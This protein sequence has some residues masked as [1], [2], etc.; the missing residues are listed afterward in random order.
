MSGFF[1][2]Q[3]HITDKFLYLNIIHTAQISATL[4]HM[5]KIG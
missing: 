3:K 1:V 5:Q 4:A 2:L